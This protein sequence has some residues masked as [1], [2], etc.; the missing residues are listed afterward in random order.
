M[1]C[2]SVMFTDAWFNPERLNPKGKKTHD[3][4]S[5]LKYLSVFVCSTVMWRRSIQTK[6]AVVIHYMFIFSQYRN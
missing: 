4:P 3:K 5:F 2:D 1:Y 6:I